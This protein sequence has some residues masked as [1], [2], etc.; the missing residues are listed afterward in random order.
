MT[1]DV[2]TA[3][4]DRVFSSTSTSRPV[5]SRQALSTLATMGQRLFDLNCA[6]T[7][8]GSAS[9]ALPIPGDTT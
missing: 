9:R 2:F 5:A 4:A 8:N 6:S 1:S 7:Q 3:G